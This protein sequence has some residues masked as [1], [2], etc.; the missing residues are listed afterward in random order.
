[1]MYVKLGI[2]FIIGLL[3]ISG[4]AWA[5][6]PLNQEEITQIVQMLTNQSRKYWI[7]SGSIYGRYQKYRAPK[8]TDP[9][10]V[11]EKI[12]QELH[13][14]IHNP[15][16][17]ELTQKLQEMTCNAI[18]LNIRF[19][20][21]NELTM[22]TEEK[23]QT[24]GDKF[25][26]DIS[27]L[28]R[29]DSILIRNR[30]FRD[31]HSN[32]QRNAK[33]RFTWDGENYTCYFKSAGQA[34]IK[35]AP[36]QVPVVVNGPLT[37]GIIPWGFGRYA[38][39]Y[40]NSAVKSGI[41]VEEDNLTQIHLTL[42]RSDGEEM[43]FILDPNRNF[44]T[45]SYAHLQADG[46]LS[47][48]SYEN[49]QLFAEYWVPTH[50]RI[51]RYQN[52]G[53]SSR[54]LGYDDWTLYFI[55]LDT[56][57]DNTYQ[58][59]YTKDTLVE[60]YPNGLNHS[61]RY[62]HINTESTKYNIEEKVLLAERL[63]R[64]ISPSPY[65]HNC[66]TTALQYIAFQ[67][68]VDL[69]DSEVAELVDSENHSTS[70]YSLEEY[71]H[72]LGLYIRTVK[73][74]LIT[75]QANAFYP[76]IIYLPAEQHFVVLGNIDSK[77]VRLIDLTEDHFFYRLT[78]DQFTQEWQ[79]G[80]VQFISDH[81]IV[82]TGKADDVNEVQR[83]EIQGLQDCTFGCFACTQM[84]QDDKTILC[85]EPVYECGGTYRIYSRRYGCKPADSGTCLGAGML[86]Y[87][88]SPCIEDYSHPGQCTVT[89]EWIS[90]SM[91]ACD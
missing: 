66:A 46:T 41:E 40:L 81:P 4:V 7:P 79:E 36:L 74:D 82:L 48:Y 23:V 27:V 13:T 34:I 88:E 52:Q 2:G 17:I 67:F 44:S 9:K 10:Q 38:F 45:N 72:R 8:L 71:I 65:L 55:S 12:E 42:E 85:S 15:H 33:R 70:L 26:W 80:I 59:E 30:E 49:H 63:K 84:L 3:I 50:I 16:K 78:H 89:G 73:M 68:G 25:I 29:D 39:D 14:H 57:P 53:G 6:R 61:L 87:I 76:A 83:K 32:L 62:R 35:E 1:M 11:Q 51:E 64:S 77:Y 19:K 69:E 22:V 47:L 58:V 18:P 86:R 54:L 20:Y 28:S 24:D 90:Y 43:F 75:L 56:P 91:R 60:Y 21:M 31:N 37:A 5:D